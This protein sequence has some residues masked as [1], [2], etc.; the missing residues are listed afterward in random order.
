MSKP[1]ILAI[2]ITDDPSCVPQAPALSASTSVGDTMEFGGYEWRVLEVS[3]REDTKDYILWLRCDSTHMVVFGCRKKSRF[4][5]AA[6]IGVVES[7]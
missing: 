5:C 7:R 6:S 2:L 4:C 1:A 3:G